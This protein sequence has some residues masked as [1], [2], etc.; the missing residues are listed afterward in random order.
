MGENR[1]LLYLALAVLLA[2][3]AVLTPHGWFATTLPIVY[4]G[5][6]WLAVLY[7][8]LLLLVLT[9]GRGPLGWIMRSGWLRGLGRISY[10]VYLVHLPLSRVVHAA[11][12]EEYPLL[13]DGRTALVTLLTLAAS[14]A[15]A[16]LSWFL[17]ERPIVRWG[18]SF[19]Y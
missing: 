3:A 19:K 10:A 12:G 9:A 4:L 7:A 14:V 13:V 16:T 18:H 1:G 8:V 15:L 17:L 6:T 5:Y 2:G 11:F